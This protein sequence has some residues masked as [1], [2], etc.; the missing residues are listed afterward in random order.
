MRSFRRSSVVVHR[1]Q[2]EKDSALG[3]AVQL[4]LQPHAH[5]RTYSSVASLT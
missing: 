5:P 2:E 1:W 4:G 3:Q